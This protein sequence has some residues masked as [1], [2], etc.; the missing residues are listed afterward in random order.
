MII[1]VVGAG[2]SGLIAGK[3]LAEAGHEVVVFDKS[4]SYGGRM[5]TQEGGGNGEIKFDYGTSYLQAETKEYETFLQELEGKGLVTKWSDHLSYS[6]GQKIFP[7]YPGK[8]K[9]TYYI[10]P[11][12]MSKIGKYLSRWLD[13]RLGV[14]VSSMT[15]IGSNRLSKRNWMITRTDVN[16]FE[17]DAIVVALPAVQ[18]NGLVQTS[19]D[20]RSFR[21]IIQTIN[22]IDYEPTIA[23][24]ASYGKQAL[25]DWKGVICKDDRIKWISNESSKRETSG[26]LG[27]VIKSTSEFAQKHVKTDTQE[28]AR[29]MLESAGV[30]AGPW[31]SNPES[32]DLHLWKYEQPR[33]P[34]KVP[35]L[36]LEN[37]SAS[38][39]LVGDYFGKQSMESAYLSGL[40]LG[41][42]WVKKFEKNK[43]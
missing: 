11:D 27:L 37:H 5:A 18:A 6:D 42:H 4:Q 39:A 38:A 40:R 9:S 32:Y 12:G 16:T 14:G 24:M 19:Q 22:Q 34:L 8:E 15:F 3:T 21:K 35:Y 28:V 36:E 1:G 30:I 41:Q 25:P 23:L 31:A 10:A 26:N 7:R 20:E 29:L 17:L 43:T 33:R 13:F 2:L